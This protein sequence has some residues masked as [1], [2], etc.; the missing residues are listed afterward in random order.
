MNL[1]EVLRSALR[2]S[3]ESLSATA[4]ATE[5]DLAALSRFRA[6]ICDLN[7][8]NGGVLAEHL[9]FRIVRATGKSRRKKRKGR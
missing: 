8:Y 1:P 4:R 2:K 5:I 6:G 7:L 3:T 9:G